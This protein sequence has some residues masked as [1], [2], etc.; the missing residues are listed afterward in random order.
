MKH[1]EQQSNGAGDVGLLQAKEVN[2]NLDKMR[3]YIIETARDINDEKLLK[4]LYI[5][6]KTLRGM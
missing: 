4:M 2:S 1:T 3:A 5:R 6:A